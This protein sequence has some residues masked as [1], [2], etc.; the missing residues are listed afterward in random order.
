MHS[1]ELRTPC[2]AMNLCAVALACCIGRSIHATDVQFTLSPRE[3]WIGSPSVMKIVVRD[4]DVISEPTLPRVP[5]LDIEVQP[6]RQSMNS[7][8]IVNGTMSRQ[9]TT[10]ISVLLTPSAAGVFA[11]PPITL[12]VDGQTFS[13]AATTLSAALSTTGD[14]LRVEVLGDKSRVWIG[15]PLGITLRIL[16]KPFRS[17]EHKVTLGEGDMWQFIDQDRCEFGPFSDSIRQLAQRGQRPLGREE[18]VDGIAYLTYDLHGEFMPSASGTPAFDD[19]RIAWNYPMRLNATRGFFGGNELSVSATKPISAVPSASAISVMPLPLEGQPVGFKGAVG[20]FELHVSAKPL[21]VAVGDPITLTMTI[22]DLNRSGGLA[23]LQPPPLET[24]E[25]LADF[26]MPSEPLAGTISGDE[27][28]FTQT[29]RPVRTGVSAIAP[30]AFSWF[31]TTTGT[32]RTTQSDPIAI[33]VVASDHISTDAI[34]GRPAGDN[35]TARAA[36][37]SEQGFVAGVQ[38]TLSMVRSQA[39]ELN[40]GLALGVLTLPPALCASVVLVRRK[41]D[42]FAGN[43]AAA[44]ELNA[45]AS[46][47]KL[48]ANGECAQALCG[49]IA[50]RLHLPSRSVTRLEAA[51][52]LRWAGAPDELLRTVDALLAAADRSRFN[53]M[54]T[55]AGN[56]DTLGA[57]RDSTHTC[58]RACERLDWTA[59][60]IARSEEHS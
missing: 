45:L 6:G 21:R 25:L 34:L 33:D 14:L 48:L 20:S 8:S 16:V 2:R 17:D 1:I 22:T 37:A 58:L 5:G 10:T 12:V 41:R 13:S 56:Q 36:T 26:R 42:R 32:Y 30:I 43:A 24:P 3:T 19:I 40:W 47:A 60:R 29:L 46:A 59:A 18:L 57:T 52:A 4:G 53:A 51:A 7:M 31:D 49:Y 39:Y 55:E 38:P 15:E 44:R 27:K 28:T 11:V 50:D 35:T 9:N 23:Q 54:Q